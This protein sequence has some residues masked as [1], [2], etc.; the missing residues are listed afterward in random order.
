MNHF[1]FVS[2]LLIWR[3]KW[4]DAFQQG[5]KLVHVVRRLSPGR[6]RY[7]I[8]RQ[9]NHGILKLTIRSG[10]SNLCI[11]LIFFFSWEENGCYRVVSVGQHCFDCRSYCRLSRRMQGYAGH[12]FET[13][14]TETTNSQSTASLRA[15]ICLKKV[16]TSEIR[17]NS[18]RM[19]KRESALFT[20]LKFFREIEQNMKLEGTQ[21]MQFHEAPKQDRVYKTQNARLKFSA[22]RRSMKLPRF[23]LISCLLATP[24]G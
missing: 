2:K 23:R 4:V 3:Q 1:F 14:L 16:V 20:H 17:V 7:A 5:N 15:K 12:F 13:T 11:V 22:S 21:Q 6:N 9:I 18:D 10:Q 8:L 24:V 19:G